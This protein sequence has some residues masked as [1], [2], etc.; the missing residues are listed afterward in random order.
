MKKLLKTAGAGVI[1]AV[2]AISGYSQNAGEI[3]W[4]S[5]IDKKTT[6]TYGDAVALF[7]MQIGKNSSGF[8]NNQSALAAEGIA[9]D[10]YTQD[11][12]L[13][14]GMLSKMTAKYLKLGGSFMYLILKTERYSYK[15][16][17]ANGIFTEDGSS[18]DLMSGPGMIEVFSKISDIKGES[19]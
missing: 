14:K 17:V 13:T 2:L 12:R 19:K 1:I 4:L 8:D 9:L 18:N 3:E 6:V 10:G 16:C 5:G 15:V 7:V 11:S